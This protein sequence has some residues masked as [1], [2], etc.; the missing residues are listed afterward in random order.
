[1]HT[2][3]VFF[4]ILIFL[5][6]SIESYSQVTDFYDRTLPDSMITE[7]ISVHGN[8]LLYFKNNEYAKAAYPGF[9]AF[10]TNNQIDISYKSNSHVFRAGAMYQFVFGQPMRHTVMPIISYHYTLLKDFKVNIG[11]IS[12]SSGHHL[13]QELQG[14]DQYLHNPLEYGLQFQYQPNWMDGDIWINWRNNLALGDSSQEQFTQGTRLTFHVIKNKNWGIDL[15]STFLFYHHGGQID[16][17]DAP[18][19]TQIN[20]HAGVELRKNWRKWQFKMAYHYIG[21]RND[22][23]FNDLPWKN[24]TAHSLI[25]NAEQPFLNLG[26]GYRTF[27]QFYAPFGDQIFGIYNTYSHQIFDTKKDLITANA[28]LKLSDNHHF[29]IQFGADIYYNLLNNQLDYN[30]GVM[31]KF[32][33]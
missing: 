28:R 8:S 33:F 11:T 2:T 24:G 27:N 21:F 23:D 12:N 19:I 30:Y 25:I 4:Y 32:T 29:K 13:I 6:L 10:G 3:K 17:S 26:I 20:Y 22:E 1:M 18:V 14:I 31:G 7:G 15:H 5:S 16:I 9:T